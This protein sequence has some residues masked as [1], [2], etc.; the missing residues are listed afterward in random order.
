[1]MSGHCMETP[2]RVTVETM[3]IGGGWILTW[4]EPDASKQHILRIE[5]PIDVHQLHERSHEQSRAQEQHDRERHLSDDE[6]AAHPSLPPPGAAAL[7]RADARH[8]I[9]ARALQCGK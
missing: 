3:Q 1:T 7:A 6:D 9:P 5:P 2:Q 4:W 8:E